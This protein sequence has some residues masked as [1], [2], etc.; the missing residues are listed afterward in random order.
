[1]SA[2]RSSPV[3]LATFAALVLGLGACT[4]SASISFD[5]TSQAKPTVNLSVD[6]ISGSVRLT[7][8]AAGSAVTGRVHVTASGF[9][10]KGQ[11]KD[12]ALDVRIREE[13]T[14]QDLAL[15]VD[16]PRVGSSKI[17]D[18]DLDLAVPDGVAVNVRSDNGSIRVEGLPVIKLDTTSGEIEMR[19]TSGPAAAVTN[20]FPIVIESHQGDLDVRTSNAP[21][22]LISIAGNVNAR[23]TNGA[24]E[25]RITPPA[26]GEVFLATTNAPVQLTLPTTYGARLLAVTSGAGSVFVRGLPFTPSGSFP[27][28]AEGIIGN[29]AGIVDVRTND[30]DIE[31]NGR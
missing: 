30:A 29:G 8:G 16:A 13:G 6:N 10:T 11:A 1:M 21:M 23:T 24:I 17:F 15:V 18:V 20:D 19:F 27:G 22:D 5:F 3:R 28:Q 9:D 25:A 2:P 26:D 4:E 14:A 7:K 12:A 31:I